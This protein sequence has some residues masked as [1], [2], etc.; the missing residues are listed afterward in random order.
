MVKWRDVP[1][2]LA[3]LSALRYR[4][5]GRELE[6]A[7]GFSSLGLVAFPVECAVDQLLLSGGTGQDSIACVSQG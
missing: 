2:P 1:G 3:R 7:E 6:A 4:W 5:E